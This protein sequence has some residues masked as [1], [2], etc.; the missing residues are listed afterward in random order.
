MNFNIFEY[1]FLDVVKTIILIL[2][3]VFLVTA[4]SY[5]I[6]YN[7]SEKNRKEYIDKGYE[8]TIVIIDNY[9]KT[10]E[11]L[12]KKDSKL[13]DMLKKELEKDK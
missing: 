11:I 1:D 6:F 7:L 12:L 4:I 5:S 3:I 2:L 13:V 9:G 10:K 8:E